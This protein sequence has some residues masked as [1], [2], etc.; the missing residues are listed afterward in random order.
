MSSFKAHETAVVETEDIGEGTRI[1]HFAHIRDGAKIGK[2]CNIGKSVY[3]DMGAVIGD[4]VKVQNFVSVYRGVVIGDDVFLGPS[5]TFTNDLYPRA[6][7]WEEEQVAPTH[8]GKGASIGANSTIVCGNNIGEYA[9]VG[10]GSVV[11]RDVP[12]F[13]LVYG[14]PAEIKGWVCYCGKKLDE[15]LDKA[16]GRTRYKCS[17]CGKAV[18][19]VDEWTKE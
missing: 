5:V 19:V 1:W 7:I 2:G 17:S 10:A 4:N 6:F 8:V 12:P 18:E 11:T 3:V 16:G 13:A 15:I 9:M 14:G